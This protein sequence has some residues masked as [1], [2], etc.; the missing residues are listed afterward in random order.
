MMETTEET[1]RA[2]KTL[3]LRGWDCPW[4][5]LKAKSWLSRMNAG[6]ILEVISS[7]AQIEK[8]FCHIFERTKDK[9]VSVNHKEECY[10]VLVKRG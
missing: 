1:Y 2:N 7:D 9:V 3:D 5:V 6:E 4:V 8:S 10:H